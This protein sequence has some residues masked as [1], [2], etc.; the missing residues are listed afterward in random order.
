[1]NEEIKQ[2]YDRILEQV[3]QLGTVR[4]TDKVVIERLAFNIYTVKRCEEQ[5]L[6]EG[7]TVLGAHKLMEHPA[8]AIKNKGE[9]KIR[10]A[11][12]LLGLDFASQLKKQI[13]EEGK[14]EWSDFL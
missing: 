9:A 6:Q 7:F 12:I 8:V 2:L 10:E 13:S 5:L 1:M 14:N 3:E 11:M 4:D